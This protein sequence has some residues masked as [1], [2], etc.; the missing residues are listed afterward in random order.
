MKI[1][2]R[3]ATECH[4]FKW[5]R[6]SGVKTQHQHCAQMYDYLTWVLLW[7]HLSFHI[8]KLNKIAI[9][10]QLIN[11]IKRW[12]S[13]RT[14]WHKSDENVRLLNETRFFLM[15]RAH[16]QIIARIFCIRFNSV[17]LIALLKNLEITSECL[18][19]A[20]PFCKWHNWFGCGSWV[21]DLSHNPFEHLQFVWC[22]LKV[23]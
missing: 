5:K 17:R 20:N 22:D 18:M 15:S 13:G 23:S 14:L 16:C 2:R 12:V 1:K 10:C 4:T 9:I 8:F 3:F 7:R 19:D 11:D 21:F 6:K